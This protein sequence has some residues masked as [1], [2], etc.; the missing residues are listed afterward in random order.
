MKHLFIILCAMLCCGA[1]SQA[2]AMTSNSLKAEPAKVSSSEPKRVHI[3]SDD[4]EDRNVLFSCTFKDYDCMDAWAVIDANDDGVYW[5]YDPNIP[6][7]Y[8]SYNY[9][10]PNDDYL[11]TAEPINIPAGSTRVSIKYE[12]M[13]M[14]GYVF[15]QKFELMYGNTDDVSEMTVLKEYENTS[16]DG[17]LEDN[18]E[19]DLPEGGEYRFAIHDISD[20]DMLGTYFYKFEVSQAADGTTGINTV[21]SV[22]KAPVVAYDATSKTI[23]A[24]SQAGVK[25]LEVYSTSGSK[26]GS[27]VAS[28][29]VCSY[30]ASRLTPGVY[31]VKVNTVEGTTTSKVAIK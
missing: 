23:V 12:P 2:N 7:Y 1:Y 20:A 24:K 17:V 8:I 31:V 9:A 26:M 10:M 28:S 16:K 29:S 18:V 19:F 15:T 5:W 14:D 4:E 27:K 13:Y 6:T 22:A 25:S 30:D 3:D 21:K 11:V